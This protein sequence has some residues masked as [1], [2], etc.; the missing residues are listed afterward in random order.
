ML[1]QSKALCTEIDQRFGV[2][3]YVHTARIAPMISSEIKR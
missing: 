2:S 1:L 3:N